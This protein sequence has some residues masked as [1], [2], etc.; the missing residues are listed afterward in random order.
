MRQY[1]KENGDKA[2]KE[3]KTF[4]KN[5]TLGEGTASSAEVVLED[6][7]Y[8]FCMEDVLDPAALAALQ[9]GSRIAR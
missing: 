6:L 2:R 5:K 4:C 3:L 1:L 7:P 8:W 9:T